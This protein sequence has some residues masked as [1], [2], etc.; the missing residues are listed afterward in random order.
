MQSD[1]FSYPT[2]LMRKKFLQLFGGEFYIDAPDGRLLFYAK[3]KAFK[4]KEDLR[5]YSD[6]AMTREVL[7]IQAR[8]ML[9]FSGAFDVFDSRNGE[10]VGVIRRQGFK[11]IVKDEWT[12]MDA[13]ETEIGTL[14]EDRMLLALIR[15][16]VPY[17]TLIPQLYRGEVRG[18]EVCTFTQNFNPFTLKL[19]LDFSMDTQGRLDRRLGIA[20]ALLMG[21][22]EG[23]EG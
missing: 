15:R 11:S 12:F 14:K 3:L 22:V 2:Y 1:P 19:T 7:S 6:M 23:K 17:G 20:A 13:D 4:L 9:D 16:F 10:K 21:A 18:E 8:Q 5:L